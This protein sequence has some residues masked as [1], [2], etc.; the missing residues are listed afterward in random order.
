MAGYDAKTGRR[1]Y[2]DARIVQA[3][4]RLVRTHGSLV[5]RRHLTCDLP[6]AIG[7]P[8]NPAETHLVCAA[9]A[10]AIHTHEKRIDL[11][12]IRFGG[13]ADGVTPVEAADGEHRIY[14]YGLSKETGLP[15]DLS[16]VIS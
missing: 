11:Q 14:I 15:I 9:V 16:E 13:E 1:I 7:A 3:L 2:G 6:K 5:M 10:E 4:K 12:T 8:G